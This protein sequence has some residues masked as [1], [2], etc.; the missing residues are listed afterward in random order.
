MQETLT[1]LKKEASSSQS[2]ILEALVDG[3]GM[4]W[5]GRK[6]RIEEGAVNVSHKTK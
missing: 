1:K 6:E 4:Y 5:G 3:N 2:H